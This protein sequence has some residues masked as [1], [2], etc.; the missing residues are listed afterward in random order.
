[1]QLFGALVNIVANNDNKVAAPQQRGG[2][3]VSA[4]GGGAGCGLPHQEARVSGRHVEYLQHLH[5]LHT[6]MMLTLELQTKVRE[7]FT[8]KTPLRHYA[9]WILTPGK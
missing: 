3:A 9:K 6:G 8:F 2:G 1:M 5:L 4:A 7:D